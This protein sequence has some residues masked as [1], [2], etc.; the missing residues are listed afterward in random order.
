MNNPVQNLLRR[1][2]GVKKTGRDQW[3]ARCPAHDDRKPSLSIGRGRDGRALVICHAG[4]STA[5]VL[6]A[7]GLSEADLFP[8]EPNRRAGNTGKGGGSTSGSSPSGRIVAQYD[9]RDASGNVLFQVVRYEPKAF[10]QRRP[11]GNGGWSWNL[12]GTPRVPYRLPE[13]LAAKPGDWV[14]VVEGEKDADSL[15]AIGLTTTTNP[16]GA[17]KWKGLSDDSALHGH[18]VAILA[19]ND[20]A[21]RQ[22]ARDVANRLHGNAADV[23]VLNLPG[24]ADKGDVSDWLDR[25][26]SKEPA[27]LA[28]ALVK[29]V[30]EAD[31]W[32]PTPANADV[33]PVVTRLSD[34]Q[35]QPVRWLWP[36]RVALGKV[37]LLA[38]DPGLGKSFLTLDMASRV[39]RGAGWPDCPGEV[40][41][42]GGVVLLSAEDDLADTIRPRLDAAGADVERIVALQAVARVDRETGREHRDAFALA[43]DLPVLEETIGKVKDCRLV[44]VDPIS[45]YLGRADSHKNA[46][47]RSLLA[48]LS[49]LAARHAVAIVAVT[50]LRKGEGPAMYRA[51]GSLAFVAAA[52]AV[53]AVTR[54]DKDDTGRRRFVLPVKNNLGNDQTGFAYRLDAEASNNGQPVVTWEADPVAITVDEALRS[55]GKDRE[56]APELGEAKRWLRDA[57]A[58]GPRPAKDTIGQ[59]RDD[60]IAK[61]TLDRARAA[62]GVRASKTG[63][64]SGWSWSLPGQD[65]GDT[66]D[67]QRLQ[68]EDVATFA[69]PGQKGVR[70]PA[71]EAEGRPDSQERHG[72]VWGDLLEKSGERT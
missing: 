15:A 61:R 71:G 23:R 55:D 30:E 49:E 40:G 48:P 54:D 5:S 38:G 45:A 72:S 17:G 13:L 8:D 57:L 4:C 19:D 28:Q 10:R 29:M 47:V 14:F 7:V 43:N 34:V 70:T 63:F 22:H 20:R 51:M 62:L 46:E 35:P 36:S 16:G 44:V 67:C 11:N 53:Y 9:Y 69:E 37:T 21:G 66:E 26:D 59:A 18:R 56:E 52:R 68:G 25:L 39:S 64:E 6:S 32:K 24:L 50:H 2:N 42:P 60:G 27:D 12:N 65:G 33:I 58:D 41:E 3:Q 1:L 31:E